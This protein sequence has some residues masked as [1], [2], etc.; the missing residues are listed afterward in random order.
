MNRRSFPAIGALVLLTALALVWIGLR[1]PEP[2][3]SPNPKPSDPSREPASDEPRAAASRPLPGL[4]LP[5]ATTAIDRVLRSETSEAHK[6]RE[7]LELLPRLPPEAQPEAL[8]HALNLLPDDEFARVRPWLAPGIPAPLAA[9]ALGE[10][11]NRPEPIKLP[12]L[13]DLVRDPR[14]PLHAEARLLLLPYVGLE[15]IDDPDQAALGVRRYLETDRPE[16][17]SP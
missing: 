11:A 15:R 17:P 7:L 8:G 4:G 1:G 14:H 13:L 16:S 6:A 12:M 2:S 3:T 5:E 9:L 10:T